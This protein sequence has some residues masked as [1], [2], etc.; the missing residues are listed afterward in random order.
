V[1]P[2][3]QNPLVV[4]LAAGG[5]G[6]AVVA[7][8]DPGSAA[9]WASVMPP[10]GAP[11]AG[12]FGPAH[13]LTD[14]TGNPHHLV[15]AVSA[16]G[17]AYAVWVRYNGARDEL[18]GSILDPSDPTRAPGTPW[19]FQPVPNVVNDGGA[20]YT[21]GSKSPSIALDRHGNAIVVAAAS[22]GDNPERF[23]VVSIGNV[24]P[25]LRPPDPAISGVLFSRSL[26]GVGSPVDKVLVD[27]QHKS[28]MG[29]QATV[30]AGTTMRFSLSEAASVVI[31]LTQSGCWTWPNANNQCSGKPD[32]GVVFRKRYAGVVGVNS[33]PLTGKR[34]RPG[35]HLWAGG[36]YSVKVVA[37][38]AA[39]H[40]TV[41][42]PPIDVQIDAPA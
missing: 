17:K 24:L 14:T 32:E 20:V 4:K 30:Y 40:Q 33:F 36:N 9:W 5:K 6:T 11:G 42:D 15:L 31:T 3:S 37:T 35:K 18:E 7:W 34:L 1:S 26:F 22:L 21:Y 41:V 12:T 28:I 10:P 39:G 23:A 25:A 19:Q 29:R 8:L 38:D 13:R 27:S 16:N 2:V